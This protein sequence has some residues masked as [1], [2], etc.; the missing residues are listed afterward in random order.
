MRIKKFLVATTLAMIVATTPLLTNTDFVSA[1][2]KVD[3]WA[4]YNTLK[5]M[6]QKFDYAKFNAELS[7]SLAQGETESGQLV[8]TANQE[9][10]DFELVTA[11]LTNENGDVFGVENIT[12][13]VQ[14]YINIL[15]KTNN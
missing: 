11:E 4:T 14:K 2:S 10:K 12:V 8:M 7:V 6:Q 1:S 15:Q 9:V 5:V 13:E 3:V